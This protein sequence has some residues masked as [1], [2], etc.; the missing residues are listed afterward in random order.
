[1]IPTRLG[2][3]FSGAEVPMTRSPTSSL[4]SALLLVVSVLVGLVA[5]FAAGNAQ[6]SACR[7]REIKFELKKS[8]ITSLE[9]NQALFASSDNGCDQLARRLLAEGASLEARDRFGAMP[10]AHAARA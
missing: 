2:S 9:T 3:M 7:E 5:A 6:P 4:S 1:M 10:L 8:Q